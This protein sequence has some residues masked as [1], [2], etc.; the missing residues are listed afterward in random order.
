VITTRGSEQLAQSHTLLYRRHGIPE[1]LANPNATVAR[2][3]Q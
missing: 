2:I 3:R 1:I